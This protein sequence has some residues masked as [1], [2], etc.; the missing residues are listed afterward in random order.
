MEVASL[1]WQREW[2]PLTPRLGEGE[3][4]KLLL[5]LSGVISCIHARSAAERFHVV[6]WEEPL[7]LAGHALAPTIRV[8]PGHVNDGPFWE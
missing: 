4:E 2:A 7:C 8:L 3:G 6:A 1:V 5:V